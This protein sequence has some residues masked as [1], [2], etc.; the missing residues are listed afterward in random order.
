MTKYYQ[1]T[2]FDETANYLRQKLPSE[3]QVIRLGVVCGSGLGGLVECFDKDPI[4]FN[5]KDIP[6]F[7][8]STGKIKFKSAW[9][10]WEISIW[11]NVENTYCLYVG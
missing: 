6:N 11:Y 5:Y 8:L 10:C 1:Q 2:T 3:L 9:S 4:E 7:L